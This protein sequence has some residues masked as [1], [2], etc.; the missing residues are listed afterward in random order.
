MEVIAYSR[1]RNEAPL[2]GAFHWAESVEELFAK[3]DV[4]TLHCPQTPE[5]AGMVNRELLAKMKP[6]AFLINTARGG[7][8]N[9]Q[10]L[11]EAL[12]SGVIAAA[13]VD[14]VSAEPMKAENPLPGAK[15]LIITPHIAWATLSARQRLMTTT[16]EN[17]AAFFAGNPQN[18]V[19]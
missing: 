2:P 15:N 13:A 7:L 4:V 14:V 6:S 9:E 16:V 10:D 19:N 12:N 17:I 11:V 18:L 8:V 1:S 3:S 5:N